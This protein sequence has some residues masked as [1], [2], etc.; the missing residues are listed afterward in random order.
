MKKIVYIMNVDWAWIKQRPHFIAEN[1]SEKFEIIII[2]RYR[3]KRYLLQKPD[4]KPILDLRAVKV[5]PFIDRNVLLKKLNELLFNN[6]VKRI[7][8]KERP[9]IIFTTYPT[10]VD[11]IPFDYKGKVIYDCMDNH[12]YFKKD[13][14]S[15]KILKE[16]E[17]KMVY[18]SSIVFASSKYLKDL[19]V[20][21]YKLD[22]NLVKIIRNAYN[23]ELL[24]NDL[25]NIP[26][27]DN[28]FNIAYIGT[29][30]AWFDWDII[31]QSILHRNN[32]V[33]HIF[34]PVDG[35]EIPK[36]ESIVYHGII[37]HSE[38]YNFIKDMDAFIMPFQVNEIIKAVDP[39]KLYEYINYNK[40]IIVCRYDEIERFEPFVYFYNNAN[41]LVKIIDNLILDNAPK[42]S[43]AKRIC[44]LQLN[45]WSNRIEQIEEIIN[46]L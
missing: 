44:F 46:S 30:G 4:N 10:H 2:Y 22:N 27:K 33:Y 18:K 37:Q 45:S 41:E 39:V 3:Y 14:N 17:F 5:I 7:I 26:R 11:V 35:T 1:L 40:N 38:I 29:V 6:I 19:I 32:V 9:D 28:K 25:I 20:N 21:R 15:R 43:N 31:I 42:Y 24:K 16:K 8:H 34:G 13:Q 23:G 36:N 12:L